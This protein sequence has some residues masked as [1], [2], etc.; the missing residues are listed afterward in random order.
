MGWNSRKLVHQV[1]FVCFGVL[2]KLCGLWDL[3]FPTKGQTQDLC[4]GSTESSPLD[5]QRIP[6]R[7]HFRGCL[8]QECNFPPAFQK[9][10]SF[11]FFVQVLIH[12]ELIFGIGLQKFSYFFYMICHW[13]TGQRR[14]YISVFLYI[15]KTAAVAAKLLQSCP[16]LCDPI[17]GSPPGSTAPGILQ[18]RTLEWVAI[19]F[20]N[21]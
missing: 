7:G 20:S 15:I 6:S 4:T 14:M 3:S 13:T 21:A 1:L 12:L 9:K 8:L 17:D 18:A 16:T 10:Y 2:A 5:L 11:S 19:S